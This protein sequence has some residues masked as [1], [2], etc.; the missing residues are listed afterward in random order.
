[1]SEE[2]R[3]Y[4]VGLFV[5]AGIVLLVGAV[6]LLGGTD[7]FKKTLTFETYF[8]ESVQGLEVGSAVR[9]RGVRI[10]AVRDIQLASDVYEAQAGRRMTDDDRIAV[11][12]TINYTADS[13]DAEAL[14]HVRAQKRLNS[15][16]EQGLRLRLTRQGITG[17][18]YI[19][20][21]FYDPQRYPLGTTAWDPHYL[22]I[23]SIPSALK[24]FS[25]AAERLL[26]RLEDVN[27]EG[28]LTN[29]G[30]LLDTL[31]ASAGE[32]DLGALQTA[33]IGMMEDFQNTSGQIRSAVEQAE[34][35][36]LSADVGETLRQFDVVL[37]DLQRILAGGRGDVVSSLDNVRAI[38]ENVRDLTDTLRSYPS[39][40]LFGGEP[41][42]S[43]VG[44]RE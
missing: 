6:L 31:S 11:V 5:L 17:I 19:E 23:P 3:Y 20:A 10:G 7:A 29:L 27:V 34:Q 25:T 16:V 37:V 15:L 2:A 18:V 12:V 13:A 41:P 40:L 43:D 26:G 32:L 35:G 14:S 44:E 38:T 33:A 36:V 22:Y 28:V 39:L 30:N 24:E 21:D 8:T 1:V 9:L 4:R 42:Q